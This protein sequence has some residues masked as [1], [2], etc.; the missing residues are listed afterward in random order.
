MDGP[1]QSR[2]YS[3]IFTA[4]QG[5]ESTTSAL[6]TTE[7][8]A[9]FWRLLMST[10]RSSYVSPPSNSSTTISL[11][12]SAARIPVRRSSWHTVSPRRRDATRMDGRRR[13]S[14]LP[15]ASTHRDTP[16]RRS[17]ASTASSTG[18]CACWK[19]WRRRPGSR[20]GPSRRSS[21]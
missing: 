15:A 4:L 5:S 9:I 1:H 11:Y 14:L 6:S 7:Q 17:S 18:S 13:N 8:M 16:A 3:I 2:D 19:R 20:S 21:R 12:L 10:A